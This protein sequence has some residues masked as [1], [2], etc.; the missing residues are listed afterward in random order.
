M[1]GK[2]SDLF[3]AS[4]RQYL[5]RS[6]RLK[7]EVIEY[8]YPLTMIQRQL[9]R[10]DYLSLK[11]ACVCLICVFFLSSSSLVLSRIFS[12]FF[13]IRYDPKTPAPDRSCIQQLLH[14]LSRYRH[15]H[16]VLVPTPCKIPS[17]HRLHIIDAR[18]FVALTQDASHKIH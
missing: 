16:F 14:P 5:V 3:S 18:I 9:D 8:D 15:N 4:Q 1:K 2:I 7:L 12:V 11:P 6:D 13:F 10:E 17:S